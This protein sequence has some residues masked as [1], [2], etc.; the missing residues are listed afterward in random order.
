MRTYIIVAIIMNTNYSN[1]ILVI[2]MLKLFHLVIYSKQ[3][4]PLG[5]EFYGYV[6]QKKNVP[7]PPFIL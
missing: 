5:Q 6:D 4:Y 3:Q 1:E 2:T 7:L